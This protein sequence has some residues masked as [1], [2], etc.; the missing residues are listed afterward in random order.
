MPLVAGDRLGPYEVTA[1]LG[2]GGMGEVYLAHDSRL[3]R[4]VAIKLLPAH[5]AADPVARER[6]RREAIAAAALDHPFIC[7]VFEIGE[8]ARTLFIAMEHV[9]GETLLERL[10]SGR[11]PL[12]ETLRVAG[13]IAEALEEAHASGFVHRDLKPANVMLTK[14]GRVKVMDFGLAKRF[15]TRPAA[16]GASTLT[17]LN[18]ELTGPGAVIGTINYMSPEQVKGEPL[19]QRSDIYSFGILLC[20]MTT[21]R[22]PFRRASTVE[23]MA[24]ILR[25]PPALDESASGE[26]PPGLMVLIRRLLSKSAAERYQSMSEVRADMARLATGPLS[27]VETESPKAARVPL[28]ERDAERSGL[29]SHLDQALAG[30][31]SLVLVSGEPGIGKTHL[32]EEILRAARRRGCLALTGHCYEMEGSPPYV[33]F[34]E[35]LEQTARMAPPETF[36]YAIGDAAPEVAK[37]MPELRR[38]FPD[39]P[40]PV[41]LPPEQQR[42]F[43]FNAYRDFVDRSARLTPLVAVFEDLHWADEPTLL[44]FEH[45]AQIA[46]N[47]SMLMIGTY[48]DVELDVNRP[49]AKTLHNL[50][51]QKL[52]TRI[53]LRRLAL[54]GVEAMLAAMSGHAPPPALARAIYDA[55]EGNP[56]FVEE[57]FQHLSEE[58]NL[59]D[60]NGAW[61]PGLRVDQLQV[62]EGVRLVIGRRLE[63]LSEETRRVLTTAAVIGRTF[64]LP[65]L[66]ALESARPDGTLEAVEE[67]EHAHLVAPERSGRATRYRFVHELI[68][69]TLALS[70]SLPRRQR[71][72]AR[73]AE[74]IEQVHAQN[75]ESHAPALAH[76]LFQA[77]AAVDFG[78]TVTWLVRAAALASSTS[79]LEESLSHLDNALSLLEGETGAAV[80]DVHELRAGILRCLGRRSEA[81]D[82]YDRALS[83]YDAAGETVKFAETTIELGS[84]YTWAFN[85]E[86]SHA[87]NRRALQRIGDRHPALRSLLLFAEATVHSV[88]G[89]IE[90]SLIE[91]E[92]ATQ[93]RHFLTLAKLQAMTWCMEAHTRFH[94]LDLER[95]GHASIQ[96]AK[97]ARESRDPWMEVETAY[98]GIASAIFRG[99]PNEAE[100]LLHAALPHAQRVGHVGGV[101][102]CQLFQPAVFLARGDLEGAGSSALETN[103]LGQMIKSPWS[104]VGEIGHA[105]VLLYSGIVDEALRC[106]QTAVDQEPRRSAWSGFPKAAMAAALAQ[107]GDPRALDML[108]SCLPALPVLGQSAAIGRWCS[109]GRVV[110]GLACL[111]RSAEAAALHPIAE[112]L[113]ATG[114]WAYDDLFLFRSVAGIAAACAGEWTRAE[115][116]HRTAIHQADTAPYRVAQPQAREW[117]AATLLARGAPD[118]VKRSRELLCEALAMFESIGMP[119]LA[120]RAADR[121]ALLA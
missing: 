47:L 78:K 109:L 33:P 111:G 77:G 89:D 58:T 86:Q 119:L 101:W 80:G 45:I 24:A 8:D 21:G 26:L 118:D 19:D 28:I 18:A 6:L 42:R 72:H 64:S 30:S 29:L 68:R 91:L 3:D 23:T 13:E 67:A 114:A 12:V 4:R 121:L 56:F 38:M 84:V 108:M 107:L 37:L 2:E 49:F 57:V 34:I 71:L 25:D 98:V 53:P 48:R 20:E 1:L 103:A 87:L 15:D 51:R 92:E 22:H 82:S 14:Q 36:R 65:L 113:V 69:Q 79:A 5:L 96:A 50:V 52:A 70:L 95:A 31:G 110:Q 81:V 112:E 116:H 32:T 85:P 93:G 11:L 66:D 74:A 63:R 90:P 100:T 102:C 73:V 75:L 97:A 88:T 9:S 41:E 120:K 43:L 117:Y 46:G 7:K 54:T 60:S 104:F 39:I 44:L 40:P 62:P 76:H 17:S 10:R 83:L 27:T 106:F 35:M 55:T 99:R 115:E 16:D 61:N 59:F 94:A 105:D